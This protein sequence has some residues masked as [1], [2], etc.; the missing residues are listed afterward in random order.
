VSETPSEDIIPRGYARGLFD[1]EGRVAVVTG[2][3]SGLGQAMAAGLA[4]AGAVLAL[5]DVNEEGLQ[6]TVAFIEA[7]DGRALPVRCDVTS[8]ASVN[9]AAARIERELGPAE[10]LVNSAGT[11][12]RC[13]AEDYPEDRYDA[14]IALNLKG[15]FL[16]CQAF[17]RQMLAR[18]R[19][20]IINIASIG[21]FNAYPHAIAYLQSKGGV[22]QLTRG[23]ALEWRDRGVRVNAIAPTLMETAL[24]RRMGQTSSV[25]SDFIRARM[26]RPRLGRPEELVGAA[27]FLA[28][29][30]SSLVTGVTLPVDDGYLVA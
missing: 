24:T 18:E 17:G 19:G 11:A 26:L 29:D 10:V 30:A 21:A 16:P 27:I 12:F 22:M 15:S 8:S 3:A 5:L 13:A 2:A 14:I 20:S 7:E 28:S 25:T 1:L 23:L 4:Q 9:E 6:E